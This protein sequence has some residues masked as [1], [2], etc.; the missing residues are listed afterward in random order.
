MAP[1]SSEP[2]ADS[3]SFT[4]GSTRL[5]SFLFPLPPIPVIVSEWA[6]LLPLIFHLTD[7]YSAHHIVGDVSLRGKLRLGIL[8]RLGILRNLARLLEFHFEFLD[9]ATTGAISQTVY[10]ANWGSVFPAAN[11]AA[12]YRLT[13]FLAAQAGPVKHLPDFVKPLCQANQSTS[14]SKSSLEPN[15]VPLQE[16]ETPKDR[17]QPWR[18][19]QIL[20]ITHFRR[21]SDQQ[22]DAGSKSPALATWRSGIHAALLVALA[23]CLIAMGGYGSAATLLLSVAIT[24][25]VR[26]TRV[27]VVRPPGYMLNNEG[28]NGC[29]LV[30]AHQNSNV[31]HLFCGD[32]GVIDTLLNKPMIAFEHNTQVLAKWLHLAHIAQ[33][34][35][36]TYVASQKGFDGIFLLSIMLAER[37]LEWYS[38]GERLAKK[39]L[40]DNGTELSTHAFRFTGRTPLVGTVQVMSETPASAWMDTIL[41]PSTRRELWLKRLECLRAH[42]HCSTHADCFERSQDGDKKWL[43]LNTRLV[44]EAVSFVKPYLG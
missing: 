41:I 26:F 29:M 17:S 5:T 12:C 27:K 15:A 3:D 20:T 37:S 21:T 2:T 22:C 38:G 33:V 11:G 36:M 13:S 34:L 8:P 10:D 32:R 44:Q 16:R 35:C 6:S 30:A 40:R 28:T 25:V 9:L 19:Y 14:T 42:V 23:F 1:Y 31:W 43:D 18:R 7:G 24:A 4:Y 39:W